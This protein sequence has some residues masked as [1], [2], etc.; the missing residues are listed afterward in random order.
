MRIGVPEPL[1]YDIPN[2]LD[3]HN[4]VL[5]IL[6]LWGHMQLSQVDSPDSC[7]LAGW[8][9]IHNRLM[10]SYLQRIQNQDIPS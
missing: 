5:V 6:P 1:L 7:V 2:L 10:D 3:R 8:A 9:H 4:D